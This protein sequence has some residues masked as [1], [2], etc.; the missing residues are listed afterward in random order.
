MLFVCYRKE[1]TA[2][3]LVL[4]VIL[5]V[6]IE[7]LR[8][9]YRRNKPR[10]EESKTST[11]VSF[12]SFLVMYYY[13]FSTVFL[14]GFLASFFWKSSHFS[15]GSFSVTSLFCCLSSFVISRLSF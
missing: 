4:A 12:L 10:P 2:L 6:S 9:L 13:F 14:S 1:V 5:H 3:S 11:L 15:C 7:K 8:K